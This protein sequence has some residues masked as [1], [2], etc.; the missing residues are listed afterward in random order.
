[1]NFIIPV[2]GLTLFLRDS[3]QTGL[4]TLQFDGI[5]KLFNS[6][7]PETMNKSLNLAKPERELCSLA[8]KSKIFKI[9]NK[10]NFPYQKYLKPNSDAYSII[11]HLKEKEETENLN[12]MEPRPIESILNI[13]K[14][15]Y[16][17]SQNVVCLDYRKYMHATTCEL[18]DNARFYLSDGVKL[19]EGITFQFLLGNDKKSL[20]CPK[21]LAMIGKRNLTIVRKKHNFQELSSK[22]RTYETQEKKKAFD[23]W[24]NSLN[25][26]Q[27]FWIGVSI[28]DYECT[29]GG[30]NFNLNFSQ[31]TSNS[32]IFFALK[33][34]YATYIP[35]GTPLLRYT[36]EN[37]DNN[38]KIKSIVVVPDYFGDKSTYF[39]GIENDKGEFIPKHY[40]Q[41]TFK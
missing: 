17:Y 27:R 25:E 22:L 23:D 29:N 10:P 1:M 30:K 39:Y 33:D 8:T 7:P 24:V 26:L 16:R 6:I 40:V 28:A 37:M 34:Q 13:A 11:S 9:Q 31:I 12:Y 36:V 41:I 38:E 20:Y 35:E 32:S 3:S 18:L 21:P 5:S 19:K 4:V 2:V 14:V 15:P